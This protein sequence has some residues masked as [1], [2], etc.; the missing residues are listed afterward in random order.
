MW[1]HCG[2]MEQNTTHPPATTHELFIFAVNGKF[3][4]SFRNVHFSIT[5]TGRNTA[6][7]CGD[8]QIENGQLCQR[9]INYKFHCVLVQQSHYIV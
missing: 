8:G 4:F 3:F 6:I 5:F 9:E 1:C 2:E 7:L